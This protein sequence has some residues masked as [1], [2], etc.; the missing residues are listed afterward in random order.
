MSELDEHSSDV[1]R[2]RQSIRL[3]ESTLESL[4][5]WAIDGTGRS[6]LARVRDP[7]GRIALVRN[8]WTDGWFL[9]GG[10]VEPGEQLVEATKREVRE[11]TGPVATVEAPIVVID[12]AYVSATDE[13][14]QFSAVQ[15][16]YA[17]FVDGEIPDAS[18]LGVADGEISAA[19]WFE[20]VPENL[21][22]GDRLR[23]Y[24]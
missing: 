8:G 17:A 9:P 10:A 3:P 6:V 11:E 20:T 24:L 16:V 2:V 15:V 4:R 12:Q 23:P 13:E 19:R 22:D 18:R 1:P 14:T 21:H 7:E 5:A